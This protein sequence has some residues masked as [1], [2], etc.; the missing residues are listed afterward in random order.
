MAFGNILRNL[1]EENNLTQKQLEKMV[2]GS[3]NK[4]DQ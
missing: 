4:E 3:K 2:Y 1:L